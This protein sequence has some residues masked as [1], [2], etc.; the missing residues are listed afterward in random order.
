MLTA[1]NFFGV[2]P[3]MALDHIKGATCI[4]MLL[5]TQ[6]DKIAT[7]Y[8]VAGGQRVKETCIRAVVVISYMLK[9]VFSK[10]QFVKMPEE[11]GSAPGAHGTEGKPRQRTHSEKDSQSS[12]T[13]EQLNSVKRYIYFPYVTSLTSC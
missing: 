1:G 4:H 3:V 11:E 7:S 9:V 6:G 12:Y 10:K 5:A 8:R 13:D 2:K